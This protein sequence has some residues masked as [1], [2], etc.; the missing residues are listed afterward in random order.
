[1]QNVRIPDVVK[2]YKITKVI[3]RGSFAVVAL[4]IDQKTSQKVAIKIIDRSTIINYGM[5][6][7]LENELRLLS[8]L[9]HQSIVKVYDVIYEEDIIMIVM[10]Y[11]CNN[12]IQTNLNRGT[13]FSTKEKIE[14]LY[15]IL[16]GIEYLHQKG[17][18]HRDIKPENIIFD[19]KYNPKLVDFGL[20]KEKGNAL[21]SFCGTE[22]YMAPEILQNDT[23]YGL[24]SDIWSFG[25]TAH[26]IFTNEY[27]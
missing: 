11:L 1:M 7:Y 6:R 26:L 20:S 4:A 27:P 14:I 21:S 3:G 9:N 25:V 15:Q 16:E 12:D 13:F 19:E 2:H 5:L 8:R 22:Y 17:I 23:Y 24:K 10:E 18:A